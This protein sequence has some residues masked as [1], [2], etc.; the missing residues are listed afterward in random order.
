MNSFVHA[1]PPF[2]RQLILTVE[3]VFATPISNIGP[4][5]PGAVLGTHE[6]LGT[7]QPGCFYIGRL[8]PLSFE[9][10]AEAVIPITIRYGHPLR[11]HDADPTFGSCMVKLKANFESDGIAHLRAHMIQVQGWEATEVGRLDDRDVRNY[12]FEAR[13]CRLAPQVL[14]SRSPSL[15]RPREGARGVAAF[16]YRKIGRPFIDPECLLKSTGRLW[17]VIV[18]IWTKHETHVSSVARCPLTDVAQCF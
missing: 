9:L 18:E 12:F 4:S 6:T 17:S 16:F 2:F 3:V 8:G 10:G 5:V 15:P 14:S 1:V 7:V 13:R 11:L